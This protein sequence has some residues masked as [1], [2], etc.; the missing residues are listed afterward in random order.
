[1]LSVLDKTG[2]YPV[3]TVRV[4]LQKIVAYPATCVIF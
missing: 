1:M 4:A 3:Y 2:T